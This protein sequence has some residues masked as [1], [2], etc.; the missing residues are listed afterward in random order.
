MAARRS[1]LWLS[2]LVAASPVAAKEVCVEHNG[3]RHCYEAPD[4]PQQRQRGQ[5][6]PNSDRLRDSA[7]FRQFSAQ[8]R[9][10]DSLSGQ[11]DETLLFPDLLKEER[12]PQMKESLTRQWPGVFDSMADATRQMLKKNDDDAKL[13]MFEKGITA[14]ELPHE[15]KKKQEQIVRGV[16]RVLRTGSRYAWNVQTD[17]N[18]TP[19]RVARWAGTMRDAQSDLDKIK[20]NDQSVHVLLM[21]SKGENPKNKTLHDVMT[22]VIGA[23]AHAGETAAGDPK[24]PKA[25]E[26]GGDMLVKAGDPREALAMYQQSLALDPSNSRAWSG[27]AVANYQLKN[28]ADAV[29]AAERALSL[30]ASNETAEAVLKLAKDPLAA[31]AMSSPKDLLSKSSDLEGGVRASGF[32]AA[33]PQA[34]PSGSPAIAQS[35]GLTRDAIKALSVGDSARAIPSLDKALEL[36]GRNLQALNLRAIALSRQRR[37]NDALR[38]A[39]AGLAVEPRNGALMNTRAMILNKMRRF[40]DA[41]AQARAA[42]AL[43]PND[44]AAWRNLAEALAGRGDFPGALEALRRAA[45]LDARFKPLLD[46]ALQLPENSDL[47]LLFNEEGGAA[48]SRAPVSG[49]RKRFGLIVGAALAMGLLLA[50][51]LLPMVAG[52]I[53]TALTRITRRSKLVPAAQGL[54]K[55]QFSL[56]RQIGYGGMGTVYEGLDVALNRRVA[57]KKARDEIKADPHERLRFLQE[58]KLVAALHHPNVVD[59]FAVAEEG[60]DVYLVFEYVDG[61]TLHEIIQSR[62]RLSLDEALP[63]L[64]GAAAALDFA[65]GRGIIHRDLKPSN[66]MIDVDGAVKVMDFGIAR[67]AKDALTKASQV[68]TNTIVGTPPYMAPEQEQ[69][70]VRKESDVYSLALCFYEML[71]GRM[72]FAGTGAGMLMSKMNK[73]FAKATALAPELPEELDAVFASALDPEPNRRVPTAKELIALVERAAAGRKRA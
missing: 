33:P 9:L 66:V 69:G 16:Q 64:R 57:I 11:Y 61:K 7:E 6:R 46:A 22:D 51:G 72:A 8:T 41:E 54:I 27:L 26:L 18:L 2:L 68:M 24:N 47:S 50:A 37:Y 49:V 60:A 53:K 67:L 55:G 38:D 56:G 40:A 52:P 36:N 25:W 1:P 4:E 17:K 15:F 23:K 73:N 45:A 28:N 5:G 34:L 14:D 10:T 3:E 59:V 62:G 58:A 44:A 29:S 30:D 70:L 71:T 19:E 43:N 63:I 35:A 65:H 20:L 13:M 21:T 39:D 32:G 31:G 12:W 48:P 42:I